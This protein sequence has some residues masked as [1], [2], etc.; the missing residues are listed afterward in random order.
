MSN[1]VKMEVLRALVTECLSAAAEEILRLVHK[2]LLPDGQA[3]TKW[4]VDNQQQQVDA[5]LTELGPEYNE[6]DL[7]WE[8]HIEDQVAAPTLTD[9]Q[10]KEVP[11][12]NI[13]GEPAHTVGGA[14][15]SDKI[16]SPG[17]VT[18][19][20]P[21]PL[22]LFR[23]QPVSPEHTNLTSAPKKFKAPRCAGSNQ[24]SHSK[25][26]PKNLG[27]SKTGMKQ[28]PFKC[29]CCSRAF[30]LTKTLIRHMKVHAE[31]YRCSVCGKCFCQKSHLVSH[32]RMHTG[33][34]PFHC[35]LA[36]RLSHTR[37]AWKTIQISITEQTEEGISSVF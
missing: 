16:R 31:S 6:Q 26:L 9:M 23:V 21:Q 1:A 24:T 15:W 2:T 25:N 11:T 36:L 8:V 28:K 37:G 13:D 33:E 30:S 20:S 22:C 4:V 17:A 10:Q 29:P 18:C 35:Q 14:N 19:E 34:K 12:R 3:C 27:Q 32:I 5:E 7:C